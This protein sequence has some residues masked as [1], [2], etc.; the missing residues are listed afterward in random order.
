MNITASKIIDYPFPPKFKMPQL[1]IFYSIKDPLNHL[2]ANKALMHQLILYFV[3]FV[4]H[5]KSC[6]SK[7][8]HFVSKLIFSFV[9]NPSLTL[10]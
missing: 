10:I 4:L 2:N 8:H 3:C 1:E 9:V 7:F 5:A 6:F